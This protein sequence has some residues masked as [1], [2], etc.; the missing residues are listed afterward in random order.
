MA[1]PLCSDYTEIE[2]IKYTT[3]VS[4]TTASC[5]DSLNIVVIRPYTEI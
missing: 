3:H 1:S 5:F 4:H 2:T